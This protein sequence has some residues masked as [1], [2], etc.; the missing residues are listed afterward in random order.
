MAQ[1]R[2]FT[3]IRVDR[4]SGGM[5]SADIECPF[6]GCVTAV[7]LVSLVANGKR[8]DCGAVLQGPLGTPFAVAVLA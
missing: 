1:E 6:C 3:A 7:R 4:R 2:L 8:C 5:S